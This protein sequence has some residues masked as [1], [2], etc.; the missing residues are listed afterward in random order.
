MLKSNDLAEIAI[1]I[2]FCWFAKA[3]MPVGIFLT[4]EPSPI[5]GSGATQFIV[6]ASIRA[7]DGVP[8][9]QPAT[10]AATFVAGTGSDGDAAPTLGRAQSRGVDWLERKLKTRL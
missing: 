2:Q 4:R 6:A 3:C 1:A 8:S 9:S 7:M 10:V 5:Q